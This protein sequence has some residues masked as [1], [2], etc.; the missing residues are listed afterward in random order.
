MAAL[1]RD[2]AWILTVSTQ[3][4]RNGKIAASSLIKKAKHLIAEKEWASF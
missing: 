1:V 3:A 2:K 4:K